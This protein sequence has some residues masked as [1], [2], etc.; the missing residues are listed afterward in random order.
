MSAAF[1]T[2]SAERDAVDRALALSDGGRVLPVTALFAR[3]TEDKWVVLRNSGGKPLRLQGELIAEGT[4]RASGGT[5]WHEIA[6]YRATDGGVAVAIRFLRSAGLENGVHRARSFADTDAA[7]TWLESFEPAFDLSADFDVSD[8]RA[9]A[10][11]VALKAA[12]LRD[13]A[14][15]LDRDYRALVGEVLYRLETEA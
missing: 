9:S 11:S 15:R 7:S 10:A 4:S 6:I 8:P 1:S 14:E 5:A 12:S 13:R 3:G 2:I